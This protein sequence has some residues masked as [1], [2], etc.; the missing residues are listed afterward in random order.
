[1]SFVSAVCV[2]PIPSPFS[3]GADRVPL[4]PETQELRATRGSPD[5]TREPSKY[6]FQKVQA[7]EFLQ[8]RPG[9]F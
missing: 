3:P 2:H 8:Q 4:G 1:M 7:A 5:P 6:P 9:S